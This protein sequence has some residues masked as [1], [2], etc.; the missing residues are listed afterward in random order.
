MS[1]VKTLRNPKAER[2][3]DDL[4]SLVFVN[5]SSSLF[6]FC[7]VSWARFVF[8]VPVRPFYGRF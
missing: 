6:R 7:I 5:F 3:T 8:I 4:A 2:L 1:A